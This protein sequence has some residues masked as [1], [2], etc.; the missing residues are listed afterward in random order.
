MN[1]SKSVQ[2]QKKIINLYSNIFTYLEEDMGVIIMRLTPEG[3]LTYLSKGTVTILGY[4]PEELIKKNKTDN[5]IHPE[6][7]EKARNH[8]KKA[9]K[10]PIASF[11][12][13]ECRIRHKNGSYRWCETNIKAIKDPETNTVEELVGLVR[14]ISTE[15]EL[16][17][18]VKKSDEK[19]K[20]ALKKDFDN[21]RESLELLDRVHRTS[22]T[23]AFEFDLITQKII[24]NKGKSYNLWNKSKDLYSNV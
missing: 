4:E 17:E 21:Q 15:K 18:K 6:D 19:E 9:L 12:T 3:K 14:D 10:H 24:W 22:K 1:K 23:G 16:K 7:R 8:R 13:N 11:Y 2:K 5:H 20:R